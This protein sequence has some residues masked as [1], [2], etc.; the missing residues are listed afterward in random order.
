MPPSTTTG[1]SF[2]AP[3]A[4]IATCGGLSTA[5]NCS[6]PNMPRFEIVNVPPWRSCSA[7]LPSRARPTRS[8]RARAISWIVR[9]SASRITGTTS[10]FGAATA[11]PTCADENR[12]ISSPVNSGVDGRVPR[13]AR[14][15]RASSGRRSLSVSRPRRASSSTRRSRSASTSVMSAETPSWNTGACHASVRRRA[16]VFRVE[17]S[18]DDL[19]LRQPGRASGRRG[20]AR[21][22]RGLLDVLGDDPPVGARPGRRA[23]GRAA[24][25]RHPPRQRRRLQAPVLGLGRRQ[26]PDFAAQSHVARQPRSPPRCSTLWLRA[27]WRLRSG[28]RDAELGASSEASGALAVTARARPPHL[29]SRSRRSSP[30]RRPHPRR[31]GS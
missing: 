31:R 20:P 23:S 11:M 21:H 10:P 12:W 5:T 24:L 13:R 14:R 16:I 3:T 6:T 15:R 17:V 18:C 8:A 9:R 1:V 27:T 30:P 29:P 7:S 2:T 25:P 26:A 19:D 22:G 28:C 4:R